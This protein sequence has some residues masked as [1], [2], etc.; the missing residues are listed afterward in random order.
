MRHKPTNTHNVEPE[1]ADCNPRTPQPARYHY[2]L[3][4]VSLT[5]FC[6]PRQILLLLQRPDLKNTKPKTVFYPN[7]LEL[8]CTATTQAAATAAISSRPKLTVQLVK[9]CKPQQHTHNNSCTFQALANKAHFLL[10]S[11]LLPWLRRHC[12]TAKTS[13]APSKSSDHCSC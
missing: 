1:N 8:P 3:A 13:T 12:S 10:L 11:W 2:H 9:L 7:Q 5:T 4:R 6:R